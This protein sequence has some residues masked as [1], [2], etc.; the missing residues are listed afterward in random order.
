MAFTHRR[1]KSL[2]ELEM[3]NLNPRYA[4]W[5]H[6]TWYRKGHKTVRESTSLLRKLNSWAANE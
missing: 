6:E 4:A 3:R 1:L 2:V 5:T